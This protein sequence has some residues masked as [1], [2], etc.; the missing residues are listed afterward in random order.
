MSTLKKER[1]W[2]RSPS[3]G[4]VNLPRNILNANA[5][6]PGLNKFNQLVIEIVAVKC[7]GFYFTKYCAAQIKKDIKKLKLV[8]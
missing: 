5:Q 4:D 1:A 3:N 2:G 7:T 8:Q 6:A